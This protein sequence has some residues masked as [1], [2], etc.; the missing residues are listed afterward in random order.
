MPKTL[1]VISGVVMPAGQ[2]RDG[3][4]S[5]EGIENVGGCFEFDHGRA[6]SEI[7]SEFKPEMSSLASGNN[8]RNSPAAMAEGRDTID[9]K[10]V[11]ERLRRV[12]AA[13]QIKTVRQ[14]ATTLNVEEDRLG[15]PMRGGSLSNQIAFRVCQT[16][17]GVTLDW[18]YFGR[19]D[20]LSPSMQ[21]SLGEAPGAD[22]PP[23]RTTKAG[24]RG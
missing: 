10:A 23:S 22:A 4:D 18:L 16:F 12:M 8:F 17:P 6:L 14:F 1:P 24:R 13:Y 15:V 19:A 3:T 2:F 20:L 7:I 5:A 11:A 9:N 21:K